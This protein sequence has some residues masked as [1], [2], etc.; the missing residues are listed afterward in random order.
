MAWGDPGCRSPRERP[1]TLNPQPSTNFLVARA[2]VAL[3]A[4]LGRF[5]RRVGIDFPAQPG[6]ARSGSSRE[7]L[8]SR[9]VAGAFDSAQRAPASVGGVNRSAN[10]HWNIEAVR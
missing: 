10:G 1:S 6:V 8:E 4:G 3:P 5:G 2:F 9:P 7:S